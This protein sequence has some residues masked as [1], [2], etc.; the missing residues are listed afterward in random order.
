MRSARQPNSLAFCSSVFHLPN[1][2]SNFFCCGDS[3]LRSGDGICPCKLVPRSALTEPMEKLLS[4]PVRINAA[5]R[6]ALAGT[7]EGWPPSATMVV[8]AML[9]AVVVVGRDDEMSARRS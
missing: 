3:L 8:V 4:S 9:S 6:R 7:V 1:R 2:L 5:R